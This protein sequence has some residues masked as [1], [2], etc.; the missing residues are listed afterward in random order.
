MDPA[1]R[2]TDRGCH[3][4]EKGNDIMVRPLLD[5]RDLSNREPRLVPD[6]GGVLLRDLAQ[7]RHCLAGQSLD[8][9]PD[10]EFALLRPQLAHLWPGITVDHP[11][12]IKAGG[13]TESV[14]YAKSAASA[15][16]PKRRFSKK[17][18]LRKRD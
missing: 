4:L 15:P 12:K 8:L 17:S 16:R 5:L 10:L 1:R 18:C 7:L 2:R 11:A 3:V 9:Q 13:E 14:L 6:R